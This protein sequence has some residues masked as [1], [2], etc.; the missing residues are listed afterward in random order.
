MRQLPVKMFL[1][2]QSPSSSQSSRPSAPTRTPAKGS[3]RLPAFTTAFMRA[4]F[5]PGLIVS[6]VLLFQMHTSMSHLSVKLVS[7]RRGRRLRLRIV[8]R[9]IVLDVMWTALVGLIWN[10]IGTTDVTGQLAVCLASAG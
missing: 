1:Q 2:E 3:T 6:M 10:T 5:L 8:A 9:I 4:L 7:L